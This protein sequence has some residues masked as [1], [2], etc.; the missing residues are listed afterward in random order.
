M[1]THRN[2]P[3]LQEAHLV[4]YR[5]DAVRHFEPVVPP[6]SQEPLGMD[7]PESIL[8]LT[9]AL[10]IFDHLKQEM[11]AVVNAR[12]ED[13]PVAAYNAAT[14]RIGEIVDVLDGS[15]MPQKRL[16]GAPPSHLEPCFDAVD[17]VCKG[18]PPPKD[19]FGAYF[20][21]MTRERYESIVNECKR[22]IRIG[23]LIQVVV[24]QRLTRRITAPPLDIYR[25]LR[26][27]NP[28]PYMFFLDFCTFQ[29]IGASPE[30]LASVKGGEMAVHPIAGTAPRGA[31]QEE[32]D[33]FEKELMENEKEIAEHVMLLD[34]GRNDVGRVGIPG[35][36]R[37]TQQMEIER[38]SHVMHIVSHVTGKL[39]PDADQF[40]ALRSAFPA[41]TV[42]GAPKIR[43]MQL[44]SEL[45]PVK[46]GA[47]A[48]AVGWFSYSGEM[49][50]C[51][52]LRT[53]I[54]KDGVAYLQ[55]GGGIVADSQPDAEYKETLQKMSA[56]ARA[57][58]IAEFAQQ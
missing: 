25:A 24:S 10:L 4:I 5:M 50:T 35:T 1:L 8:L 54:V 51:I 7:I 29:I 28:S 15:L 53:L 14:K 52:A 21:N 47:Y 42:S 18:A 22:N 27:I 48:G 41:G 31:T 44:I 58:E 11:I 13:D 34:L 45:E 33:I 30:L 26:S 55:A 43:A 49:D 38:Y 19:P 2:S 12:V 17:V 3:V 37:V 36:V 9:D 20:A 16:L 46:R 40:D 23:E 32:D 56:L 57:I 39:S 6:I